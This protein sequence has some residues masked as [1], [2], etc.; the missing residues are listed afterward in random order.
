M[1]LDR[2][3]Y[4]CTGCV[5]QWPKH[6]PALVFL[7]AN[8]NEL[9]DA[10]VARLA[11]EECAERRCAAV[12][13]NHGSKRMAVRRQAI[14]TRALTPHAALRPISLHAQV[15][16][17]FDTVYWVS[18][19]N[20]FKAN[21]SWVTRI[22]GGDVLSGPAIRRRVELLLLAGNVETDRQAER[23]S[24]VAELLEHEDELVQL[25]GPHYRLNESD[26]WARAL[27]AAPSVA[28]HTPLPTGGRGLST[29]AVA[30]LWLMHAMPDATVHP[31]GFS[32]ASDA[33]GNGTEADTGR[34]LH[35]YDWE[36]TEM[37]A[38]PRFDASFNSPDPY[39]RFGAFR[40]CPQCYAPALP[41]GAG[42]A[43]RRRGGAAH[44]WALR[45][46][47]SDS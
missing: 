21:E 13:C 1:T 6:R 47:S 17:S 29:G 23:D 11:K 43:R 12:L 46:Y 32:K 9:D 4:T 7:F 41:A 27:P 18:R 33:G 35:D 5:P 42:A 25:F 36:W 8:S 3:T 31:V 28:P 26:V 2:Y 40:P 39:I 19:L 24:D 22:N 20:P 15:L 30:A 14:R 37:E 44:L 16:N 34:A 45:P 38:A 10:Y